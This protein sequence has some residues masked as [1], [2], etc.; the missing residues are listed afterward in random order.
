MLG[1]TEAT[2]TCT[3]FRVFKLNPGVLVIKPSTVCSGQVTLSSVVQN[4]WSKTIL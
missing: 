2:F 4:S 1:M 3:V